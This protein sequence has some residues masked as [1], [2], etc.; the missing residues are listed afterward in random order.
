LKKTYPGGITALND[1]SFT[2]EKGEICGYLG[3]NGA[4]KTTTVKILTGMISADS[5]EVTLNGI[6]V[7]RYPQK[8]K[9]F[10]GYVPETGTIFQALTPYEFLEFVCK[11][12]DLDYNVYPKKIMD[13]LELF[14]LRSESNTPMAA[15]S[16]GMRQKVLI[17]SSLIHNPEVIFWDEP[18][19]GLDFQSMETVKALAQEL[20]AAGKTFFYCSHLLDIVERT[21]NRI[22][23]LKSGTI[24]FNGRPPDSL[25]K[26][27]RQHIDSIPTKQKISELLNNKS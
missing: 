14:E 6:D 11:I 25:E 12:Y 4:G 20:S 27:F 7:A 2:I 21:C 17:I 26:L 24:V 19:S 1:I 3:A 18:L 23:I 13:F 8:V 10:I 5:G 9:R 15:F 16:K 22:I